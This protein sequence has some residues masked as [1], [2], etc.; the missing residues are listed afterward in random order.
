MDTKELNEHIKNYL[1]NDKT[2]RAIMLTAPWGSGKS[3]YIK[4]SLCPFL[5]ENELDY[6]VVSLYGL[7]E[8]KDINK[9]LYV[10]LRLK[11]TF[12]KLRKKTKKTN[13]SNWFIRNAE[14][15]KSSSLVAGKTI[16][17]GIASFFNVR[18]DV[19]DKD[20]ETLLKSINLKNKLIIFED[21]ERAS[22]NIIEFLGYINNLT[23]Q[24]GVKVLIVANESEILKTE[25]IHDENLDTNVDI[26]TTETKKYLKIKEKTIGDTIYFT[27]TSLDIIKGIYSLFNNEFFKLIINHE[28]EFTKNNIYQKIQDVM[29]LA[30]CDNY[31]SLLYACQKT[32]E[33]F[34]KLE[35]SDYEIDYLQNVLLG[36]VAYCVNGHCANNTAWKEVSF[37]STTLGMTA[38]P[39]HR[40]MYDYI[41]FQYFKSSD[42]DFSYELF[43]KAKEQA[44]KDQQLNIVYNYPTSKESDIDS[45]LNHIYIG[46]ENDKGLVHNEYVRI[47]NYLISIKYNVGFESVVDKCLDQMLKNVDNAIQKGEEVQTYSS[48]GIQPTTQEE[49]VEFNSF[50]DKMFKIVSQKQNVLQFD[51]KPESIADYHYNILMDKRTFINEGGFANKLDTHKTIEMFKGC[52]PKEIEEFRGILQYIYMGVSNIAHFM[53][54]DAENLQIIKNGV[55]ELINDTT[56][57][58]KVQLLQL[59]WLSGNLEEIINIL[60]GGQNANN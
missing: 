37:T 45:A 22:I 15:I 57:F 50:K 51:Y 26:Y 43:K 35:K 49:L 38:F 53:G 48:S 5:L 7:D 47:A 16:V 25:S 59:K 39:L 32:E 27:G 41:K 36:T 13:N 34:N 24:D 9:S 33:I 30:K 23:E 20:I 58:D 2:Q 1:L 11:K 19:T 18:L 40:F 6:A 42:F 17:K 60:Q 55:D 31:R 29:Q 14:E 52:S 12:R 4:N 10:E 8:I 56:S 46:L 21:L 28:N 3:Y 54:C 44:Q